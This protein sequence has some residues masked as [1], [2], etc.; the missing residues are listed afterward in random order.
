MAAESLE[1]CLSEVHRSQ[2]AADLGHH[3]V[4]AKQVDR[5]TPYLEQAGSQAMQARMPMPIPLRT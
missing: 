3:W 4:Q 1:A 2:Q 5:A